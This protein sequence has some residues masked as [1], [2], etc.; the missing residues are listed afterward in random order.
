MRNVIFQCLKQGPI[1]TGLHEPTCLKDMVP[2]IHH[3]SF[4]SFSLRQDFGLRS[5][6]SRIKMLSTWPVL[7]VMSTQTGK[8][9]SR[10]LVTR[11]GGYMKGVDGEARVWTRC[12]APVKWRGLMR[13]QVKGGNDGHSE[14]ERL[15]K[16]GTE[17]HLS[18]GGIWKRSMR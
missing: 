7:Q 10:G 15:Q 6:W 2:Y 4:Y 3:S 5:S 8:N 14:E 9:N 1:Q 18:N 16:W 17:I 11:V 12:E 13:R